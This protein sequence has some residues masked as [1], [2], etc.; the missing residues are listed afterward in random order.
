MP[1]FNLLDNKYY[2][3]W[4]NENVLARATRGLG[5]ALWKGGDQMLID[6]AVVNGSW[7]FVGWVSGVVRRLQSGYLYHYALV[8]ILG[9]F[10]LMTWFVV[11][12]K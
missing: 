11:L 4:F 1:I 12:K 5:N 7:R 10:L 8:M 9:I 3:D 6:G 2:I